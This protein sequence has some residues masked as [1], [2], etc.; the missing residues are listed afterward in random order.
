[1]SARPDCGAIWSSLRAEATRQSEAEPVLASYYHSSVL[2]HANIDSALTSVLAGILATGMLPPMLLSEVFGDV[3]AADPAIRGAFCADLVAHRTRDPA[4][5]SYLAPF[6]HYKGFHALQSYR[7]AHRLWSEG[8]HWLAL[9]LQDRISSRFGVD[10][11]PAATIGAGI[12]IDHGTGIVI[13]ETARVAD[14]VS[15]LHGLTLGG[16]GCSTADRH[17]KVETGVLFGAGARVLGPVRIG[18]GAKVG[19]GS[20]VLS[21][22]PPHVTVAG[23]PA[24]VVG[25]PLAEQ[26]ALDMDHGFAS[27]HEDV[28]RT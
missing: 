5:D 25:R 22:V 26:P 11:H 7:M 19:A 24:R 3:L 28:E 13:G 17:P 16:S 12:M 27:V 8:R 15:M 9:L 23:V 1:V 18:E 6:L 20:L 21:D 14:N 10:I 2:G 4:C